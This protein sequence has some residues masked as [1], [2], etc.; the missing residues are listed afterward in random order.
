MYLPEWV[1]AGTRGEMVEALLV[2]L[3][4][5]GVDCVRVDASAL[6]TL[7]AAGIGALLHVARIARESTG[8]RPSLVHCSDALRNA[9]AATAVLPL[10]FAVE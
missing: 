5:G 4:N 8:E 9:L 3:A 10:L 1:L 2:A 7:D 6:V